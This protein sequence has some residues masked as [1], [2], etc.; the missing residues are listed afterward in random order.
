MRPLTHA[1]GLVMLVQG[2]RTKGLLPTESLMIIARDA[3]KTKSSVRSALRRY[4]GSH[5]CGGRALP[6]EKEE[7]ETCTQWI[8]KAGGQV[9]TRG[10]VRKAPCFARAALRMH[11]E[12][13]DSDEGGNDEPA[14]PPLLASGSHEAQE[15]SDDGGAD[16]LPTQLRFDL[17][18][19]RVDDDDSDNEMDENRQLLLQAF[20]SQVEEASVMNSILTEALKK[21]AWT[22]DEEALHDGDMWQEADDTA[23][24]QD[25]IEEEDDGLEWLPDIDPCAHLELTE[26][27]IDGDT[28]ED[29]IK[30]GEAVCYLMELRISQAWSQASFDRFLQVRQHDKYHANLWMTKGPRQKEKNPLVLWSLFEEEMLQLMHGRE[31]A[32]N[33]F[34]VYDAF[35][36]RSYTLKVV[37]GVVYADTLNGWKTDSGKTEVYADDAELMLSKRQHQELAFLKLLVGKMGSNTHPWLSLPKEL[38]D[39]IQSRA[40]DIQPPHDVIRPYHDVVK[41]F[42]MYTMEDFMNFVVYYSPLVFGKD[43]LTWNIQ[44]E[45]AWQ[46]LR[47]AVLHYVRGSVAAGEACCEADVMQAR[48]AAKAN[49]WEHAKIMELTGPA[50]MMTFNMRLAAVHLYRQEAYMGE[51]GAAMELWVERAIQR[52]KGIVKACGIKHSPVEAIMNALCEKQALQE[53]NRK[54]PGRR[55]MHKL[56]VAL[57]AL[58]R[59]SVERG[60]NALRDPGADDETV[61]CYFMGAGKWVVRGAKVAHSLKSGGVFQKLLKFVAMHTKAPTGWALDVDMNPQYDAEFGKDSSPDAHSDG[62]TPLAFATAVFVRMSLGGEVYTSAMYTRAVKRVSYHVSLL[63][64]ASGDLPTGLD[65][66]SSERPYAKVLAYYLVT[67]PGTDKPICHLARMLAYHDSIII[68]TCEAGKGSAQ[69]LTEC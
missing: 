36:K 33:P 66:P 34:V 42:G 38:L 54:Y 5:D 7:V 51:V 56:A 6:A 17:A 40:K 59:T 64:H 41:Y 49:L 45:D 1:E 63:D 69:L 50:K 9:D 24:L 44:M 55:D 68:P 39:I 22:V 30:L 28:G 16:T 23:L 8:R 61:A 37:L 18:Q 35:L 29:A 43:L 53:Y 58:P 20:E 3:F 2:G 27:L 25:I 26:P 52:A 57:H 46:H 62:E 47:R 14:S 11:E 15:D 67:I 60:N 31:D 4:R 21:D 10:R 12:E 13:H 19:L 48:E 32:C 65:V